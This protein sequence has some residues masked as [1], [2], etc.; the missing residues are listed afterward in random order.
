MSISSPTTPCAP[1][2]RRSR[3]CAICRKLTAS[4]DITRE[5]ADA[6][7]IDGEV[8][9][10]VGQNC[11]VTLEP[12]ENTIQEAD[13]SLVHR[14]GRGFDRRRGRK[15]HASISTVPDQV[16]PI[17]EG[18]VDLG[19]IATEFFL[20]GIDPYPRKEDAVFEAPKTAEDPVKAPVRR[21]P[22][23]E[24]SRRRGQDVNRKRDSCIE[25]RETLLSARRG[26]APP[27]ILF[28][29][30]RCQA[31]LCRKRFASRSTPWA[32]IMGPRW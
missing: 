12:I 7:R 24:K 27:F 15:D 13:Q 28:E 5:G 1:R 30:R 32:E 10:I 17:A 20:L 9:A 3:A 31:D 19:A 16:E 14:E 11:V 26:C 8:S 18:T 23:A 2:S 6:V 21:S 4:F 22:G 25:A 29:A